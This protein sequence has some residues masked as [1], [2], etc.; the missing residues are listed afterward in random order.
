MSSK[1]CNF[2]CLPYLQPPH[3]KLMDI[4]W[5]PATGAT[6]LSDD[7]LDVWA[8][9]LDAHQA[10][11]D[12]LAAILS[13]AERDRAAEYGL[14]APR[15][16]FIVTRAALRMLLGQYLGWP[17]SDIELD[18]DPHGKPRLAAGSM[19]RDLRFNVAHSANL[20]LIAV[21]RGS[22]VGVDAERVRRVKHA[23][24]IAR[25]YFHPAEMQ[26]VVSASPAARDAV[27][28]R[29]WT[30]K[31]AVLKAI[32]TGITG[33]LASFKVPTEELFG[34]AWID[35]PSPLSPNFSRCW[36]RELAPCQQYVGAVA[37]CA[38][39]RNVRCFALDL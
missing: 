25:R 38:Q 36:L 7:G 9:S 15:Q 37:C 29:C 33:S 26:A 19:A 22:E 27:F 10:H 39:K 17:A 23:D 31:E 35:L 5:P 34:A 32:G 13:S 21:T 4:A 28:M 16:R 12:K 30:G 6:T 8:L 11:S 3:G 20:A 24:H 18:H 1:G 14:D 2:F